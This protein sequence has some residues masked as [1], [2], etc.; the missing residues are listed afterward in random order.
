MIAAGEHVVIAQQ[1]LLSAAIL[2]KRAESSAA[3]VNNRVALGIEVAIVAAG[4]AKE[5]GR[6]KLS[7][8]TGR[9]AH[10][11]RGIEQHCR[12]RLRGQPAGARHN[13]GHA[14]RLHS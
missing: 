11:P 13:I 4:A 14:G 9:V 12:L 5:Y 2:H 7:L 1:V 10:D 6:G 3:A 8:M